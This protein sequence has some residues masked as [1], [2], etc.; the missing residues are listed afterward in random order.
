SGEDFVVRP[1]TETMQPD[2]KGI[3]SVARSYDVIDAPEFRERFLE[4]VDF[5]AENVPAARTDATHRAEHGLPDFIPLAFEIV[6][7]DHAR[8]LGDVSGGEPHSVN[9]DHA[10]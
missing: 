9:D 6:L 10:T 1:E 4:R 5:L 8:D 7:Q 2:L 3:E